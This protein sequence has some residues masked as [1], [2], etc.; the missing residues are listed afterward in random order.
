MR[1]SYAQMVAE[2][3]REIGVLVLVFSLLDRLVAGRI[4]FVW[5]LFAVLVSFAVFF[6]G[7]YLEGRA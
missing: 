1:K 7:C 3:L 4:T 2:A 6:Y 5:V